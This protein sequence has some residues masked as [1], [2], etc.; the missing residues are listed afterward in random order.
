MPLI[1]RGGARAAALM[2]LMS[3]VTSACGE[4]YRWR[5]DQGR[6][7]FSDRPVPGSE[8]LQIEPPAR[9]A[10]GTYVRVQKVYDGDTVLLENGDKVRLL[11][12]NTPEVAG[13]RKQEEAGGEAAK[14]W[15]KRELEGRRVRLE[16]DTEFQDHYGRKLAH[17]FTADGEH[18]NRLLVEQGYATTDIY[19]PNLKY[20][21]DMLSAEARAERDKKGL[22]A[23]PEYRAKT[24]AG[25]D[26]GGLDGWQRL[27]GKALGVDERKSLYI[28]H[29]E[30][31]FEAHIPKQN[32]RS[33]PPLQSYVGLSLELRG[34]VS[35]RGGAYFMVI[36]HPGAL[37]KR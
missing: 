30:S 21:D 19:P 11:G 18:V 8:R 2:I 6:T 33:F 13:G 32:V 27:V 16:Q 9:T 20:V 26:F 4:V 3:L 29:F 15:L 37:V 36:R 10:A 5:D 14:A 25:L 34:W 1:L 23:L 35:R 7:H 17:V 24:M 28:L 22:W 31:G 12:I